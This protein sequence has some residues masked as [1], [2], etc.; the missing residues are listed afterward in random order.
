MLRMLKILEV[1]WLVIGL[2]SLGMGIHT[3][4]EHGWE[5]SQWFF[6]G[7]L[8]ATVFYTFRRRQRKRIEQEGDD[9]NGPR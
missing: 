3:F 9:P 5:A 7:A 8:M 4:N 1:A 2:F 6:G